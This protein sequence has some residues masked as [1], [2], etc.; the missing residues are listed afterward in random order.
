MITFLRL[1]WSL[2]TTI[3]GLHPSTTAATPTRSSNSSSLPAN[4]VPLSS[5]T[6]E[7]YVLPGMSL[8]EGDPGYR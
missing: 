4:F 1:A 6:A 7:D 3:L 5:G 2:A 8:E